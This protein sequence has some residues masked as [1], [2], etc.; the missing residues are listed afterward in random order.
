MHTVRVVLDGI[1]IDH[2]F[3]LLTRLFVDDRVVESLNKQVELVVGDVLGLIDAH[4]IGIEKSLLSCVIRTGNQVAQ[5]RNIARL[6]PLIGAEILLEDIL[7]VV[8]IFSHHA[9]FLI[10]VINEYKVFA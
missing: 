1:D 5:F 2:V 4:G 8:H 3:E 7:E 10:I 6:Q 9:S